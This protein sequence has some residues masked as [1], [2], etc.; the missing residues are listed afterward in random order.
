MASPAVYPD[1]MKVKD[2]PAGPLVGPMRRAGPVAATADVDVE[3]PPELAAL[4][5]AVVDV[6]ELLFFA[7]VQPP[8]N[9]A[10]EIVVTAR[11]GRNCTMPVSH[12]RTSRSRIRPHDLP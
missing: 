12:R 3:P 8:T 9:I 11:S 10:A 5:A 2:V 4:G 6:D 1:A 7:L